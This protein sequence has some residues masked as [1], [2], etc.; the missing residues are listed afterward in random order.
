MFICQYGE[1]Q[2]EA[3]TK[4]IVLAR[5]EE[6]G[7]DIPVEVYACDEHKKANSFFESK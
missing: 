5:N 3:S 7:K 1:C 6:G 2:K 4:G